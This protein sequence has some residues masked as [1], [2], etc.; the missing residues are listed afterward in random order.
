MRNDTFQAEIAFAPSGNRFVDL[1]IVPYFARNEVEEPEIEANRFLTREVETVGVTVDNRSRFMLGDLAETTLTYGFEYF[2][3]E[4]EGADSDSADG[5][6]GGVPDAETDFFGGFIQ[7]AVDVN[8]LGPVPGRLS[9]IPALRYDDFSSEAAGFEDVE[10]SEFSPKIGL[11]YFPVPWLNLFGSYAEGFRA[12]SFNEAYADGVHFSIPD[13]SG[14]GF[15]PPSFVNNEFIPNPELEAETSETFEIGAAIETGDLLTRGDYAFLKGSYYTSDVDN[16]IE[17]DVNTPA[18]CFGA[19]FPPCGSGAAFG[20]TSQNVNVRNA[21]IDG[22]EIEAQY[23]SSRFFAR[24]SFAHIDG[25]DAATGEP[26]G[27]LFPDQFYLDGGVKV[28]EIG[29]RVGARVTIA[30]DFEEVDDPNLERDSFTTA[31]IYAVWTPGDEVFDGLLTGLR[32]DLGVENISDEDFEI[33]SAGV[34]EPGR[35]FVAAIGYRLAF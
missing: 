17:L 21:E 9:L 16:L 19:P 27:V 13:L 11:S 23:D 25:E 20:N 6:R 35:N 4:Q 31:D 10:D 2:R 18:G 24:A 15:G 7:A 33:V 8:D 1:R 12:P 28:V 32:L 30:D 14:P 34:S 26:V 3:D 5:T 22:V 29:A